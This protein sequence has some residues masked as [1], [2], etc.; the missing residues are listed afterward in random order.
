MSSTLFLKLIVTGSLLVA[1]GLGA[2]W[3]TGMEPFFDLDLIPMKWQPFAR[4]DNNLAPASLAG[5][6][7]EKALFDASPI[8]G[9]YENVQSKTSTWMSRY[10]DSTKLVHMNIPGVHDAATWNYSTFTHDQMKHITGLISETTIDPSWYRCQHKSI[11]EMLNAGIRAFDLRYAQDVTKSTLV[12]WHGPALQSQ[13]ATVD[14]VMFGFYQWLEHHPSETLLLS[15][16]Y[17]PNDAMGNVEDESVQHNLYNTLTGAAAQK[18]I[19]QTRNAFGNLGP[20]RGKIILLR[21][22]DLDHLPARFES[23]IPGIHFSPK[24]WT[25]NSADIKL[26]YRGAS[27]FDRNEEGVAFIE[28]YYQPR[29]RGSS[30]LTDN[31][32]VKLNATETHL[33][34]AA[35]D[36]HPDA[37]FWTFTSGTKIRNRAEVVTPRKMAL[38]SGI[39]TSHLNKLGVNQHLLETLEDRKGERLGIV[40]FDFYDLPTGLIPLFLSLRQP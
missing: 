1:G 10:P 9:H 4:P 38:G 18:Y 8:F 31:I 35:S 12:F 21:R 20:A 36:E 25:V 7:I 19:M 13:T 14:S 28:D 40:M 34:K 30:T 33:S 5:L 11:I 15:F 29:T 2:L 24:Q 27:D 22:F 26:T 23:T 17:E 32:A 39:E 3:F 16:Q 37:L 6:A